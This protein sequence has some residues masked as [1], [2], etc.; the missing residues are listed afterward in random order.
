MKNDG[1]T[2]NVKFDRRAS[3]A[4]D[5]ESK[6]RRLWDS[7]RRLSVQVGGAHVADFYRKRNRCGL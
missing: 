6:L 3:V 5:L 1:R 7:S 2:A 4:T